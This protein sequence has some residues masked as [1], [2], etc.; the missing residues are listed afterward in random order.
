MGTLG[1]ASR[2][3]W[4]GERTGQP[5]DRGVS[6]TPKTYVMLL[7]NAIPVNTINKVKTFFKQ[8]LGLSFFQK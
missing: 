3:A 4:G 1:E 6:S 7:T 5:A 2:P 8:H